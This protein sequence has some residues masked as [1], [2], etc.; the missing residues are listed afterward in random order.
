MPG[1]VTPGWWIQRPLRRL[2]ESETRFVFRDEGDVVL[3]REPLGDLA[4][5]DCRLEKLFDHANLARRRE[6]KRF[7]DRVTDTGRKR[8]Q[9]RVLCS[10][11]RDA[12]GKL[13]DL[14]EAFA[15]LLGTL[16]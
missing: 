12:P 13:V 2:S 4:R 10:E 16:R 6:A 15:L 9:L 11:L 5:G 7:H 1:P 3:V 14:T 8:R